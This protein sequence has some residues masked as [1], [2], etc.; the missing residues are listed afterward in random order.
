MGNHKQNSPSTTGEDVGQLGGTCPNLIAASSA[1]GM[2]R[3]WLS[4]SRLQG[5]RR[6]EARGVESN[7][8]C[9]TYKNWSEATFPAPELNEA[10][11]LLWEFASKAKARM[12]GGMRTVC[13]HHH[14]NWTENQAS[15]KISAHSRFER[16]VF[17]D[18]AAFQLDHKSGQRDLCKCIYQFPSVIQSKWRVT[19]DESTKVQLLGTPGIEPKACGLSPLDELQQQRPSTHNPHTGGKVRGVL[20]ENHCGRCDGFTGRGAALRQAQFGIDLASKASTAR[21]SSLWIWI[22]AAID[23][24]NSRQPRETLVL[25]MGVPS[26]AIGCVEWF[27]VESEQ[28]LRSFRFQAT[29]VQHAVLPKCSQRNQFNPI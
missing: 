29:R 15:L 21:H 1:L 17:C 2:K 26:M 6:S 3:A 5:A 24:A 27:P 19:K 8:Q 7:G 23:S 13:T 4:D 11:R 12:T 20:K 28:A 18:Q 14:I 9:H 22:S 16:V 10:P 25:I